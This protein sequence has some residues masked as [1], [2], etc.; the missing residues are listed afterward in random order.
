MTLEL[1]QKGLGSIRIDVHNGSPLGLLNFNSK[2][3][4][5]LLENVFFRVIGCL[6]V[7]FLA[8]IRSQNILSLLGIG[9]IDKSF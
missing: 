2:L 4:I 8:D 6:L 1:L 3:T 9:S 7:L 5:S